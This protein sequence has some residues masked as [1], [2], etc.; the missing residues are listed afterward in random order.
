MTSSAQIRQCL[1]RTETTGKLT[2]VGLSLLLL[3]ATTAN[4]VRAVES[5]SN[6]TVNLN[7]PPISGELFS[8]DGKVDL[9]RLIT[10][11]SSVSLDKSDDAPALKVKFSKAKYP[12]ITF[13][14]PVGGWNLQAFNGVEVELTNISDKSV[15]AGL[16]VDN[17]GAEKD[18]PWN[19]EMK[20]I[21]P[22]ETETIQLV[23]GE[24]NGAPTFPLDPTRV[25]D[26][27]VFLEKPKQP[28]TLLVRNLKGYGSS[29]KGGT[30]SAFSKIEDRNN[31]VTPPDWLGKRP[32]IKG[33]WIMT[34]NETFDGDQ[35]NTE[36][37]TPRLLWDGPAKAESQRYIEENVTVKDGIMSIKCDINPGHQYNDPKLPTR[38][39]ATGAVTSFDKWTQR[40]GYI[41]ARLKPPIARGLWP[42]FWTMPDRGAETGLNVWERRD[43]K[44]KHGR[45]MEIDIFEHLTEWGPGRTN[46]AA[47]WGGYGSGHQRWGTNHVYY[48]PTADGWHVFGILWE[49]NKLTWYIDGVKKGEWES[50]QIGDVP[51]YLKFTV[52]MG[53]WATKDVDDASLP[54][55][56]QV[57][58]VR[59]WQSAERIEK[60]SA[61]TS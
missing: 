28:S 3:I 47:H 60:E 24:D 42:A 6:K 23:F 25:V 35:L 37:W 58:Y 4:G 1:K 14:C 7:A 48:G 5:S 15:R 12:K 19:T 32:P 18:K 54:D 36:L 38:K 45:G 8:L 44:N 56:F 11:D 33:D 51:S 43:T 13:P 50:D 29:E 52:Q 2:T 22:G 21:G 53:N 61:E 10:L 39:Y 30:R 41:E 26:I 17:I 49:P 20:G 55:Y 59:A 31:P 57:D 9:S 40:Y 46:I 16:R 27:Q 34:L